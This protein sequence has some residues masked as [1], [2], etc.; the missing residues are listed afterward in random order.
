M[1]LTSWVPTGLWS[2]QCDSLRATPLQNVTAAGGGRFQSLP[3]LPACLLIG[4]FS[5]SGEP[6]PVK[7][8]SEPSQGQGLVSGTF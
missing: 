5:S 1:L 8:R 7:L 6:S 4:S 2:C 3:R